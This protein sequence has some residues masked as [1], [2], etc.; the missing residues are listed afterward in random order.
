MMKKLFHWF[1]SDHQ[2]PTSE[3]R[4]KSNEEVKSFHGMALQVTTKLGF[5]KVQTVNHF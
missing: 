2:H 5:T 1:G 3:E 4:R